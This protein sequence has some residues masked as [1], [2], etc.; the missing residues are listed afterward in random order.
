MQNSRKL[1]FLL[2]ILPRDWGKMDSI[3]RSIIKHAK[4][5]TCLRKRRGLSISKN[6]A[7]ERVFRPKRNK[8]IVQ[9]AKKARRKGFISLRIIFQLIDICSLVTLQINTTE[10]LKGHVGE[11]FYVVRTRSEE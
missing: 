7:R 5:G 11:I 6:W 9:I 3:Y 8:K 10:P 1:S 2:S 4:W